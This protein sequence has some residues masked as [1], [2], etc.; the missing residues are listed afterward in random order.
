MLT[1]FSLSRLLLSW[2][3]CLGCGRSRLFIGRRH[4]V[5]RGISRGVLTLL[6]CLG[7]RSWGCARLDAALSNDVCLLQNLFVHKVRMSRGMCIP[8][9]KTIWNIHHDYLC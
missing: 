3:G 4:C 8:G 5:G 2:L 9:Q 7:W 6:L 1:C